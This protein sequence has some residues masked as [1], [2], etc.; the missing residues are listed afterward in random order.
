MESDSESTCSHV[1]P[2]D[3]AKS[4][5]EAARWWQKAAGQGHAGAQFA[6]GILFKSGCGVAKSDAE[7]A[8]WWQKAADQ[9]HA[10]AQSNLGILS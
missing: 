7:A 4:D 3:V 10:E 6:L 1:R 2:N 8:R 9:G 5:M